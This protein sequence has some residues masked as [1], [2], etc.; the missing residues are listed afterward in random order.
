MPCSWPTPTRPTRS[1]TRHLRPA[2]RWTTLNL[3]LIEQPLAHDDIIDHARLQRALDTPI[4]LDE[5]IHS[6]DDAR[7]ALDLGSCRIINI[8]V[9]RL[10]GLREAK[11][12][13]DL[14]HAA[15]HA[16]L[17]RRHA[18]VRHRPRGQRRHLPACPASRCPATSRAP[19]STT[20]RTS[21]SRRFAPTRAPSRCR[22]TVLASAS[23][24]VRAHQGAHACA[25]WCWNAPGRRCARDEYGNGGRSRPMSAP[26]SS[27][28]ATRWSIAASAG[29]DRIAQ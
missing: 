2:A 18:R 24:R 27:R 13:H 22:S 12:V 16:G 6:A 20:A 17:V 29:G 25:S 10:G 26:S 1:K 5:S 19:T 21:S 4:C 9:S 3:L 11:R 15:R 23:S 8:K 14:C 28:G 7:K